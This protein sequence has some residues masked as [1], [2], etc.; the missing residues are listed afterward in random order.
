[1]HVVETPRVGRKK[2]DLVDNTSRVAGVETDLIQIL[3]YVRVL[4]CSA[5]A[6]LRAVVSRTAG[7]LPLAF[8][9]Q[10]EGYAGV[11]RKLPQPRNGRRGRRIGV[12][13]VADNILCTFRIDIAGIYKRIVVHRCDLANFIERRVLYRIEFAVLDR[14]R[15]AVVAWI[16]SDDTFPLSLCNSV[17]PYIIVV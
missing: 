2:S 14:V 10:V 9:W 6:P 8:A 11:T 13:R 17:Y 4:D 15:L 3:I 1:M 7:I 5:V 12:C 16:P